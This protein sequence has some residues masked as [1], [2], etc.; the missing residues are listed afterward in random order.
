[1]SFRAPAFLAALAAGSLL[2]G[3]AQAAPSAGTGQV[4]VDGYLIG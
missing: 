4:K 2:A 1:M 3:T